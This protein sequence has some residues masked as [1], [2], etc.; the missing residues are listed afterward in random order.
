M[1]AK[2]ASPNELIGIGLLL[3]TVGACGFMRLEEATRVK[4]VIGPFICAPLGIVVL[5]LGL[6]RRMRKT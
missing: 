4:E 1:A 6:V 3:I 2:G 5:V